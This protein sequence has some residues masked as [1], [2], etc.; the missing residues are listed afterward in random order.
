MSRILRMSPAGPLAGL[1]PGSCLAPQKSLWVPPPLPHPP[2]WPLSCPLTPEIRFAFP[3]RRKSSS[4]AHVCWLF[5]SAAGPGHLEMPL[6]V[7]GVRSL[8]A[9]DHSTQGIAC[10]L[11]TRVSVN[12][13][14]ARFRFYESDSYDLFF[15]CPPTRSGGDPCPTPFLS[16]CTRLSARSRAQA[17]YEG[18]VRSFR[19]S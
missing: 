9:V 8:T 13:P 12:G 7:A 4:G 18:M 14:L 6:G 3:Y 1:P 19:I 5:A 15:G 11:C 16:G 10:R 2:A 17:A